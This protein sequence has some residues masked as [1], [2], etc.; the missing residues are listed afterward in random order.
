MGQA[1]GPRIRDLPLLRNEAAGKRISLTKALSQLADRASGPQLCLVL[2]LK[3]LARFWLY[4][5]DALSNQNSDLY[6]FHRCID[7][8]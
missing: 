2:P 4:R 8:F 6:H 3:T 1:Q 7:F 5:I